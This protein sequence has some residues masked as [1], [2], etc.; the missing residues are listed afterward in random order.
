M[1]IE[2][3]AFRADTKAS[4]GLTAAHVQEAAALYNAEAAPAP[5]PK[6]S[7]PAGKR[8]GPKGRHR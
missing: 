6:A 3:E 1:E 8:G 4:K 7:R 2:V 5:K